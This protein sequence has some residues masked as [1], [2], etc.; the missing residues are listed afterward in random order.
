MGT[1]AVIQIEGIKYAEVYK[2]WDGSPD[3]TLEWLESFNE[4][5]QE[6]RGTD[7]KYKF[8]QLLRS[9]I[10]DA[11]KFNLDKSLFTGWGVMEGN[12]SQE[13]WKYLYIL[14]DDGSVEVKT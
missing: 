1:H 14:K 7:P 13:E 12:S 11:E 2:H 8:A 3:S 9:S 5:F 10:N 4:R 6:E